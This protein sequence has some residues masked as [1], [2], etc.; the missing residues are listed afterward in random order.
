MDIKAWLLKVSKVFQ[1][2]Y[3]EIKAWNWTPAQ[4]ELVDKVWANLS[5]TIQ[6]A[7]WALITLIVTKYGASAGQELLAIVLAEIKKRG[8]IIVDN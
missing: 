4:Q 3:D 5:P 8:W 2:K 1:P 7:L 6:K